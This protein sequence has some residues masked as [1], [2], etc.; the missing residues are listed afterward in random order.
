VGPCSDTTRMR[1]N[2]SAIKLCFVCT[3]I[4]L[5]Q[6]DCP[7]YTL[8]ITPTYPGNPNPILPARNT[9]LLWPA[10]LLVPPQGACLPVAP[11]GSFELLGAPGDQKPIVWGESF[12]LCLMLPNGLLALLHSSNIPSI[13]TEHSRSPPKNTIMTTTPFS[14]RF[15]HPGCYELIPNPTVRTA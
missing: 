2:P 7:D 4:G 5:I 15:P 1:E 12:S 11:D 13:C 3:T 8:P 10:P 14:N 6:A 9:P